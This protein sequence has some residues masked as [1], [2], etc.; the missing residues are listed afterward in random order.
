MAWFLWLAASLIISWTCWRLLR[1][2]SPGYTYTV[3]G[4]TPWY[5]RAL[6]AASR[7]ALRFI[8]LDDLALVSEACKSTGLSDFGT[9]E[10]EGPHP[11]VL[12]GRHGEWREALRR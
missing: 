4:M 10:G 7:W 12:D 5:V 1:V 11:S 8:T 3:S 2:R 6:H 9:G